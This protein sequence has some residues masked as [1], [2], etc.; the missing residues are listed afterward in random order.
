MMKATL[1]SKIKK[2]ATG[3]WGKIQENE[4]CIYICVLMFVVFLS[5]F[6][7]EDIDHTKKSHKYEKAIID[8]NLQLED[9]FD[10]FMTVQRSMREAE[11]KT[12]ELERMSLEQREFI[13]QIIIYLKKIG[14]WPPKLP[15]EPP[16]DP[17]TLAESI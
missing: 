5:I 8:L 14:H 13:R 12:H 15:P 7:L 17:N 6:V 3:L 4:I 16:V 2:I 9:N 1:P 11:D 10:F